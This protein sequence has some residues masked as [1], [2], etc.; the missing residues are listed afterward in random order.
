MNHFFKNRK[1]KHRLSKNI[2]VDSGVFLILG[3]S[4]S[5]KDRGH[6]MPNACKNDYDYIFI[7][8]N[9]ELRNNIGGVLKEKGYSIIIFS[10]EAENM[11][12]QSDLIEECCN[13]LNTQ[14]KL[15]VFVEIKQKTDPAFYEVFVKSLYAKR[16]KLLKESCVRPMHIYFNNV[17]AN[18]FCLGQFYHIFKTC[19]N[20]KVG[21][22]IL[23]QNI[24]NVKYSFEIDDYFDDFMMNLDAMVVMGVCGS[25]HSYLADK[26]GNASTIGSEL[27]SV[28]L[29]K[30]LV[31]ISSGKFIKDKKH[32]YCD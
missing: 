29:D 3:S 6:I 32:F 12:Y 11:E 18:G 19:K 23:S 8:T 16:F 14:T 26:F 2:F 10:Q 9:D 30:C 7:E 4:G 25:M 1:Q 17:D 28:E 5:G 15:A 13:L 22:S 20:D 24:E 21:V 31:R 27:W